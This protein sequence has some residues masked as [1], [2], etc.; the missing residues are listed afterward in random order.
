MGY[1]ARDELIKGESLLIPLDLMGAANVNIT[2]EQNELLSRM[3]ELMPVQERKKPVTVSHVAGRRDRTQTR[4]DVVSTR[5][6]ATISST[7]ST[8]KML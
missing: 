2:S 6:K 7:G 4:T 1:A 5:P 8:E 3:P